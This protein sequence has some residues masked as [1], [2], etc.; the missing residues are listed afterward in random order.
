MGAVA[1]GEM[2]QPAMLVLLVKP[3]PARPPEIRGQELWAEATETKTLAQQ[4][5]AET[6]EMVLR[7]ATDRSNRL[8]TTQP[9]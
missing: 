3:H 4:R 1:P 6:A 9:C 5:K 8:R 7:G 2:A